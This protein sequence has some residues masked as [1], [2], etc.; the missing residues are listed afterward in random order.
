MVARRLLLA[1]ATTAALTLVAF[2]CV[3]AMNGPIRLGL[4]GPAAHGV[5]LTGGDP[6]WRSLSLTFQGAW[7]DLNATTLRFDEGW[8]ISLPVPESVL[9]VPWLLVA[10]TGF[11]SRMDIVS[12]RIVFWLPLALVLVYPTCLLVYRHRQRRN[13]GCCSSC[14][15]DLTGN[16][17]GRCPECGNDVGLVDLAQASAPRETDA[18]RA[19]P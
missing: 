3:A 19:P 7:I 5:R 10:T 12:L 15:Y 9:E 16:V 1:G 6:E 13:V 17:S 11:S 2:V 4:A 8:G 14:A 18:K